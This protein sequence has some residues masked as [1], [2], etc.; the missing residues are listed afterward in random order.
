M[1]QTLTI[2]P[3][4]AP[5]ALSTEFVLDE[6]EATVG[7]DESGAPALRV[8]DAGLSLSLVFQD[9][10]ALRRFLRRVAE[11]ASPSGKRTE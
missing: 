5:V 1:R 8:E 4:V 9:D 3:E 7:Y 6:P 11:I 2:R 10:R